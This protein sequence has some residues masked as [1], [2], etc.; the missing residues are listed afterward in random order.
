M[1]K[2]SLVRF[3]EKTSLGTSC[4]EWQGAKG[5]TKKHTYGVFEGTSAS[6]RSY[7]LFV[8]EIP[9]G[10]VVDHLCSNKI[11]VNPLHLEAIRQS[12]NLRRS[13]LTLNSQNSK[14]THCVNGHE[15]SG[16]NIRFYRNQRICKSCKREW[17]ASKRKELK[18]VR[19]E[20][21]SIGKKAA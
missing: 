4:W 19:N 13:P 17:A 7:E 5:G 2:T 1:S 9:E 15:L 12:E 10:Y 3:L 21:K 18:E 6:R 20:T 8:G 11:C 14:L 16:D